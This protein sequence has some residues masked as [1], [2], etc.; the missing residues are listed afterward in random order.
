M[1]FTTVP[2]DGFNHTVK[3]ID[4]TLRWDRGKAA[5]LFGKLNDDRP[6]TRRNSQVRPA[7]PARIGSHVTVRG[8]TLECR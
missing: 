6:L 8:N 2:I 4:S 3:G 5:A 7:D 1:E